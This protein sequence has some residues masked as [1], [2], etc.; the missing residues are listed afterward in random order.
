ML[1][2]L[3]LSILSGE[4]QTDIAQARLLPIGT[5][6]TISG[7][8][9]NGQE[10]GS[11][12]YIEDETGGLPAFPGSGSVSGF[13]SQV[14][15]GDSLVVTGVLYDFNGLLELSPITAFTVL[16]TNGTV[17][18][19]P[20]RTIAQI[21]E[22]L[23]GTLARFE[24]VSF[25]ESGDFKGD[26]VYTIQDVNGQTEDVYIR[27]GQDVVGKPIPSAPVDLV[28]IISS[29]FGYQILPRDQDD[30][31]PV[32]ELYFVEEIQQTDL[33]QTSVSFT[34]ETNLSSTGRVLVEDKFGQIKEDTL[35]T[36]SVI[37]TH[38]IQDL[39]P[40]TFYRVQVIAEREVDK[41]PGQRRWMSTVS[42]LPGSIAVYFNE[43]VD[44]T[45]SLGPEPET[46]SG[47]DV[48]DVMIE[49]IQQATQTIDMA[50]YNIDQDIIVNALNIA[51]NKG[52]RVRYVAAEA[53]SNMA[54]S[55]PPAFPVIYGN[56]WALMHNK[57]MII[58][59]EDPE[60]A[61][62]FT[63]SM[64]LTT[65]QILSYPNNMVLI[66]DQA[67]ARNYTVEFEEM[68]GSQGPFPEPDFARFG[69]EKLDNT[70]H[71][72]KVNGSLVESYF[73]PSDFTNREILEELEAAT[74]SIRFALLTFTRDD[75]AEAMIGKVGQ[76][77]EVR[78][79]IE[80]INDNGSEYGKILSAGV[81]VMD[82]VP[83]ALLHHKY[84]LID[85]AVVITGSHN[86]SNSAEQQNDENTVIIHDPEIANQF[87][88]EF[89]ARWG[90]LP[91]ATNDPGDPAS[92]WRAACRDGTIFL[93]GAVPRSEKGHVRLFDLYGRVL[94]QSP[95]EL[96]E[97]D[98]LYALACP[99]LPSG[100]VVA[101][102]S[103]ESGRS[104]RW[105]VSTVR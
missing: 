63:G 8:V 33:S 10:L 16:Q 21:S 37:H 36:S 56:D 51:Y 61:V 60:R 78:G 95:V 53:T 13:A 46:T 79:I 64:N 67:M 91:V 5:T 81:N 65:S 96:V 50:F 9:T 98:H 68:W 100:Y 25:L 45:Y 31:I 88:Q 24:S 12:R 47:D 22:A 34:W 49:W 44:Q 90:E 58:D 59:A 99:L 97:G 6:V 102:V 105:M 1:A 11:I 43:S 62:V 84:A 42:S 66:R 54:L 73:S 41:V 2:F 7:R 26:A 27:N 55:P 85:D 19:P 74:S 18:E 77:L 38:T 92:S 69:A 57:F 39:D 15:R 76:G 87:R 75:L 82:H 86:W 93:Y 72:F 83:S 3:A 20:V 104:I 30:L 71:L 80:N 52:I 40:A 17:P 32:T 48:L 14:K 101:E 29:Y 70:P 35:L 103:D 94:M 89:E 4:A 28:G 23:E